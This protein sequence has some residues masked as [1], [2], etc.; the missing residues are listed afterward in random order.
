MMSRNRISIKRT[1]SNESDEYFECYDEHQAWHLEVITSDCYS[2]HQPWHIE[3]TPNIFWKN[4][5]G[6][7]FKHDFFSI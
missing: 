6:L 4:D 3:V 7:E 1:G 5:I 2:E